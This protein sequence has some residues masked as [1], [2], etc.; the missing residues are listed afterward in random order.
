MQ[1]EMPL[2]VESGQR[3]NLAVLALAL[4]LEATVRHVIS[5]GHKFIVGLEFREPLP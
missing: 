4:R 5:R 3:V 2:P 1:I